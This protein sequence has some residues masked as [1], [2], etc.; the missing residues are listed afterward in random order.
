MVEPHHQSRV[1]LSLTVSLLV[2]VAES[3]S[4]HADA[5]SFRQDVIPVL[6]KAGCNAGSCHGKLVGQNGFKL[7]LRGY[8]PEWD[9]DSLVKEVGSRRVDFA[10]P[11]SSLL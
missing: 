10:D 9:Y 8:A 2:L 6:T 5:P 1:T 3:F 4:A 11:A 7:S